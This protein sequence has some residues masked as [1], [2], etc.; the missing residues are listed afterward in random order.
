MSVKEVVGRSRV[1]MLRSL[2]LKMQGEALSQGM[3]AAPRIW[4]KQGHRY[5][6]ELLEEVRSADTLMLAL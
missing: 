2:A 5:S 4:E 6:L 1:E 3:G